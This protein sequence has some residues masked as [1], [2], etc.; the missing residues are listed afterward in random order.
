MSIFHFN[1]FF[2]IKKYH[3]KKLFTLLIAPQSH[4]PLRLSGHNSFLQAPQYLRATFA[5]FIATLFVLG[6][7]FGQTTTFTANGTFNVPAGVTSVTVEAWGGGGA[8]G[9]TNNQNNRGGGGGAGGSYTKNTTVS[10]TPGATITVSIGAGGVGVSNAN[11]GVG[12]TS[13]FA[14]TIPVTA[15]GG[16]GGSVGNTTNNYGTGAGST[17]GVTFNGGAGA[18]GASGSSNISGAGGGGAGSTGSGGDASGE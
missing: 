8:G 2:I 5:F 10:V 16:N 6:D 4:S 17:T 14:S 15:I 12:G 13:T 3:M 9:G 18:S 11:G 7:V 1:K